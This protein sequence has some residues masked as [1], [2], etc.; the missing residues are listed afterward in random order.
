MALEDIAEQLAS[1]LV[2]AREA[3]PDPAKVQAWRHAY[4]PLDDVASGNVF[5]EA[6]WT[7]PHTRGTF[8]RLAGGDAVA[9]RMLASQT[10]AVLSAL[11]ADGISRPVLAARTTGD[12]HA[13]EA[14][15]R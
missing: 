3:D 12:A 1:L 14:D 11:P 10:A 9:A 2:L 8:K 6:W 4:E 13:L 15:H 5:L 7:R